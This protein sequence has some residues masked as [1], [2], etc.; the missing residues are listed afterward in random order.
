M[1]PGTNRLHNHAQQLLASPESTNAF[2]YRF[3][4][5]IENPG[6][7]LLCHVRYWHGV[8]C[9]CSAVGTD[10][11]AYGAAVIAINGSQ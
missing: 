6:T 1:Y 5:T 4:L 9:F 8:W 11:A 10:P 2:A 7:R 3:A